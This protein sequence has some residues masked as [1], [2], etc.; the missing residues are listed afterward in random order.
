MADLRRP[1]IPYGSWP[2]RLTAE[3]ILAGALRL[4]QPQ[5]DRDSVYWLEGRPAEG[6]RQAIVRAGRGCAGED[7]T[8]P[9]VNVRTLVHEY[10]GGD[11]RVRDSRLAYSDFA[12]QRVRV[13]EAGAA[14]RIVTAPGPRY[15][16]F[17]WSP[18]GR[19]L[20]AVEENASRAGSGE[21]GR[22]SCRERV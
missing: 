8:A 20:V 5:L 3:R 18:D 9:E 21:I 1:V 16:D 7:V 17:E 4:G 11:Y 22:A 6:G 2:S 15:A 14:D 13:I 12:D 19:F 10:G